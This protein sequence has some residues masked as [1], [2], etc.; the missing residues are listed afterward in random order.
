M[1]KGE[2]RISISDTSGVVRGSGSG[3]G[4]DGKYAARGAASALLLQLA[5]PSI[6]FHQLYQEE[7][8]VWGYTL[9][10][11]L[12]RRNLSSSSTAQTRTQ[13]FPSKSGRRGAGRTGLIHRARGAK[14]QVPLAVTGDKRARSVEL[15][16]SLHTADE[17]EFRVPA[18]EAT[19]D[20]RV[21]Q[22]DRLVR[23]TSRDVGNRAVPEGPSDGS[24]FAFLEQQRELRKKETK[25]KNRSKSKE[26]NSGTE[27]HTDAQTVD[28]F[29]RGTEEKLKRLRD[30]IVGRAG[31]CRDSDSLEFTDVTADK[32]G[33]MGH[34]DCDSDCITFDHLPASPPSVDY[35]KVS[36]RHPTSTSGDSLAKNLCLERAIAGL[37]LEE[38]EKTGESQ[39]SASK[40]LRS[41]II[42]AASDDADL[43][44]A[45]V[46]LEPATLEPESSVMVRWPHTTT[47]NLSLTTLP[48]YVRT[49]TGGVTKNVLLALDR[50]GSMA[51]HTSDG[52]DLPNVWPVAVAAAKAVLGVLDVS[53]R[54]LVTT[55]QHP[56]QFSAYEFVQA[57][58]QNVQLVEDWLNDIVPADG[59][60]YRK[61]TDEAERDFDERPDMEFGIGTGLITGTLGV[62]PKTWRDYMNDKLTPTNDTDTPVEDRSP[63]PPEPSSL[64]HESEQ[65]TH[66]CRWAF[67]E[68]CEK[69]LVVVMTDEE[70]T[71]KQYEDPDYRVSVGG[72]VAVGR[73][74]WLAEMLLGGNG[75]VGPFAYDQGEE[76][77]VRFSLYRFTT[78][79]ITWRQPAGGVFPNIAAKFDG[80]TEAVSRNVPQ[81][82][83]RALPQRM[84]Q[85]WRTLMSTAGEDQ[86][87]IIWSAFQ[88]ES[89]GYQLTACMTLTI[90]TGGQE[91]EEEDLR[92]V[93][94]LDPRAAFPV[95]LVQLQCMGNVGDFDATVRAK[96]DTA[97]CNMTEQK[98][99]RLS[100][101]EKL[102][103]ALKLNRTAEGEP[104]TTEVLDL[105]TRFQGIEQRDTLDEAI[106]RSLT[107]IECES[108]TCDHLQ[109][110]TAKAEDAPTGASDNWTMRRTMHPTGTLFVTG[111]EAVSD[112][113]P[114]QAVCK[115]TTEPEPVPDVCVCNNGQVN[116]TA[117]LVS[118]PLGNNKQ[119]C[120]LDQC[121][122][123]YE[124]RMN[125]PDDGEVGC[126]PSCGGAQCL[127]PDGDG[128][129][130]WRNMAKGDSELCGLE[131][132][133]SPVL[134]DDK[135]L[136][137]N[138]VTAVPAVITACQDSCC[139]QGC[140]APDAGQTQ[141]YN[142]SLVT[143][144]EWK[145][146][147]TL[148]AMQPGASNDTAQLEQLH[149]ASCSIGYTGAP[150]FYC[151]ESG[152]ELQKGGCVVPPVTT[153]APPVGGCIQPDADALPGYDFTDVD[154]AT[155]L[156]HPDMQP[157]ANNTEDSAVHESNAVC[158]KNF[159]GTPKFWCVA[160]GQPVQVA[161]C[162]VSEHPQPTSTVKPTTKGPHEISTSSTTSTTTVPADPGGPLAAPLVG[163]LGALLLLLLLLL[164][165][166]CGKKE[167]E[168]AREAAPLSAGEEGDRGWDYNPAVAALE[169][170]LG[171][172][173]KALVG[174]GLTAAYAAS[175]A[176]RLA[177]ADKDH[178]KL[179]KPTTE[180]DLHAMQQLGMEFDLDDGVEI[181]FLRGMM[182]KAY[183]KRKKDKVSLGTALLDCGQDVSAAETVLRYHGMTAAGARRVAKHAASPVLDAELLDLDDG[184]L[185]A[186]DAQVLRDLGLPDAAS[187]S[188]GALR[189]MLRKHAGEA[190]NNDEED[191]F[192]TLKFDFAVVETA[193]RSAGL[194]PAFAKKLAKQVANRAVENDD[195]LLKP[196]SKQDASILARVGLDFGETERV[197]RVR[198]FFDKVAKTQGKKT[199]TLRACPLEEAEE[200]FLEAGFTQRSAGFLAATL[201][202]KARDAEDVLALSP[203]ERAE[204]GAEGQ[205]ATLLGEIEQAHAFFG[206][207]YRTKG[208]KTTPGVQARTVDE[209]RGQLMETGFSER[210]A[211]WLAKNM[212][213]K[214]R[215]AEA[216]LALSA[217]DRRE[218]SAEGNDAKL[219][220]EVER[221]NAFTGFV[222]DKADQKGAHKLQTC[223]A[224]ESRGRFVEAGFSKRVAGLLASKL[225]KKAARTGLDLALSAAERRELAA[226]GHDLEVLQEVERAKGWAE[227]AYRPGKQGGHSLEVRTK[228]ESRELLV[229]AGFSDR[230]AGILSAQLI[231]KARKVDLSLTAKDRKDLNAGEQ[232]LLLLGKLEKA[233]SWL[234]FAYAEKPVAPAIDLRALAAAEFGGTETVAAFAMFQKA[235]PPRKRYPKGVKQAA[236]S[237]G[238]EED[239]DDD[240]DDEEDEASSEDERDSKGKVKSSIAK[241]KGSKRAQ[242]RS[243]SGSS[244][245]SKGKKT[246]RAL[247]KKSPAK[248][249][250]KVAA[251]PPGLLG[252]A[253]AALQAI[254]F[255]RRQAQL[256]G[257]K[258]AGT[259]ADDLGSDAVTLTDEEL[260][261][262]QKG[263]NGAAILDLQDLVCE[264]VQQKASFFKEYQGGE[265]E[266]HD[267]NEKDEGQQISI[268]ASARRGKKKAKPKKR[269]R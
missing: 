201:V 18:D 168:A 72:D 143:E 217:E 132:A 167:E 198:D 24:P 163:G 16:S 86:E 65:V 38:S 114:E 55:F 165:L 52:V 130:H 222:Y 243:R 249:K 131:N 96:L 197:G 51:D 237:D 178:Q 15:V 191:E 145:R 176:R 158:A 41:P 19:E 257:Q 29:L 71:E 236:A 48:S 142:F 61:D 162:V 253:E 227:F 1:P 252:E 211:G 127:T 109:R 214:T 246:A 156:A 150:F 46:V 196:E 98:E 37:F 129:Y 4:K 151:K 5:G 32:L 251:L 152:M 183:A 265:E 203:E 9:K 238:S 70:F 225:H 105:L 113:L 231:K 117:N 199:Q 268:L 185:S 230:A 235:M 58:A 204:L 23:K 206:F 100:Y 144:T 154:W 67:S 106:M 20:S 33:E 247:P 258:I 47:E 146:F 141:A 11:K 93:V 160:T 240:D 264:L 74:D 97:L 260:Q 233:E 94:C 34:Q 194:T 174:A 121:H 25:N 124:I 177:G 228:E 128:V 95:S 126:Y 39:A 31:T 218:L 75:N 267:E 221:A 60:L 224:E 53:D 138:G 241:K 6:V 135:A 122:D 212:V 210:A 173:E 181:G 261:I 115:N 50:S 207:A 77:A 215:E 153:M 123:G 205:D 90:P 245:R 182:R 172:C 101:C 68:T 193:L 118:C 147:L 263:L 13:L 78:E 14:K 12:S 89:E 88:D 133:S 188:A 108:G 244:T 202:R 242:A 149:N 226:E 262:A 139:T 189:K 64:S 45:S 107:A 116:E 190:G 195:E 171:D 250:A 83:P 148:D 164:L 35:G 2:S 99:T 111:D 22:Q 103:D 184:D 42:D 269:G 76:P 256:I 36:V 3:R 104:V 159:T 137:F 266:A 220:G 43:G 28:A 157:G 66:E 21:L 166:C 82:D 232:D 69:T 30:E 255:T 91:S 219:L 57:S 85:Y 84:G 208:G 27:D 248:P 186:E 209:A 120:V 180:G 119:N 79:E 229:E 44:F 112:T 161:G 56:V 155:F 49:L 136:V 17:L 110:N 187:I 140:K 234:S 254:G 200:R 170:N 169:L 239:D 175:A 10:K 134:T 59:A 80:T 73:G 213:K 92:G 179:E 63:I 259:A 40:L 7:G 216:D 62:V 81:N 125:W 8:L 54:F 192:S 87:A 223:T 102:Q 26:T